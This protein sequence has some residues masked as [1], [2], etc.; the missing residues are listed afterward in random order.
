[1]DRNTI[2]T[3]FLCFLVFLVF[4]FLG[5]KYGSKPSPEEPAPQKTEPSEAAKPAPPPPGPAP[6]TLAPPPA[7]KSGRA[8][9]EVVVETPLYR[10]VFSERGASLKSFQLK[11]YK[12]K[13][14]HTT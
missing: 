1:M 9:R 2:L 8:A 11:K 14:K 10:A 7:A 6:K 5:Q 12:Q 4:S 3:L 13:H